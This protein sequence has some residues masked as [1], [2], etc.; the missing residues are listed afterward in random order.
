MNVDNLHELIRRYEAHLPLINNKPHNEIFKWAA[1][2]CFQDEWFSDRKSDLDFSELFANAKRESSVLIDA[3]MTSPADGIVKMAKIAGNE[4]RRLFVDVLFADDGGDLKI[5]Q[6][7]ME[8]FLDEIE[9]I[10]LKHFPACFRYKQDWHAVS[11][12]LAM[13][14]P[15]QNYIYKYTHVERF[16]QYIEYGKDIGSGS[17]FS[18]ENYYEMCDLIVD[19]LREHPS[20]LGAHKSYL[21]DKHYQDDSLHLMAF[22]VIYCASTYRLF[23]GLNHKPKADTIKMYASEQKAKAAAEE[24]QKQIDDLEEQI[25]AIEIDMDPYREIDL[26]GTEVSHRQYGKG[27]VVAQKECYVTVDFGT[28]QKGFEINKRFIF[29]PRFQ[30]DAQVVEAFTTYSAMIEQRKQLLKQLSTLFEK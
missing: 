1:V 5:R 29:R 11:C 8:D 14:S 2:R 9:K 16:A 6:K 4:V 23:Y 13:H 18:L 12:Y 22:D 7:H 30:D 21:T 15:A 24:K 20:L 26:I 17:R 19:A 10:R 25:H 28:L 27:I 3:S